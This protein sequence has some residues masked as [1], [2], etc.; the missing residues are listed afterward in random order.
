MKSKKARRLAKEVSGNALYDEQWQRKMAFQL[1]ETQKRGNCVLNSMVDPFLLFSCLLNV[2]LESKLWVYVPE[3]NPLV[4]FANSEL[5]TFFAALRRTPVYFP[6]LTLPHPHYTHDRLF[7]KRYGAKWCQRDR[8]RW[9]W[10]D[11]RGASL[12]A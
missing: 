7:D 9:C 10:G 2:S 6:P 8:G 3:N 5:P 1:Q 4:S 11:H 12:L